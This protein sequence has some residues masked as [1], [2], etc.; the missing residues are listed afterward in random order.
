MKDATS[1][2][3]DKAGVSYLVPF[4]LVSVLFFLWGFCNGMIDVLDKHFQNSLHISK[5]ESSLVASAV[6]GAYFFM[7]IPAGYLARRFGYKGGILIGLVLIAAGCFWF[8]PAT[9]INTFTA[10]LAGLFILA[11]GLTCL[12]TVANPYTTVLGSPESSAARINL[13]QT[14]NSIGTIFGPVVAGYFVL[15]STTEVNTSNDSLYLPYLGVGLG[16]MLLFTVFWFAS[17]PEIQAEEETA[18][19]S[20]AGPATGKPLWKRPHFI[21]AIVAQFLYVAAQTGIFNF[22]INYVTSND[23]PAIS[24]NLASMIPSFLIAPNGDTFRLTDKGASYLLSGGG[25]MLFFLGR[26][27]GSQLLRFFP[28]HTTLGIFAIA[29]VILMSLICLPLGWISFISLF[30]SFFFISIM[31]P[32]IFALGIRG[33]G[34]NTKL[35]S[36]LIVMAI[37]GGALMPPLMGALADHFSMRI[38]FLMPLACFIYIV[39]YAFSWPAMERRDAGHPVVD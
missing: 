10:F 17:L 3:K 5:A 22:F 28:A 2:F 6:Y 18:P 7:A 30:L 26:F 31:F 1:L 15:S 16:V 13:A 21:L 35:A 36:S 4:A 14:C 34:A 25:M 24:R 33:L 39:F 38:G 11:T 19:K 12:E 23:T 37:L 8:I 29:N 27:I 32:T 20:G 9:H